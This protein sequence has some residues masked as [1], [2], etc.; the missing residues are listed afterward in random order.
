[1][2]RAKGAV[3]NGIEELKQRHR[4][5]W[6]MGDYP[7]IAEIFRDE[8][9]ATVEAA[10]ISAGDEVLDVA[11]GNGNIAI[12]A[13]RRGARVVATDLSPH[14]VELGRDRTAAEG[15]E[16]EWGEADVEELP[17]ENDRFDIVTSSFGAMFAPRPERAAAEMFRVAKPGGRV[18]M[19]NWVPEGPM[20]LISNLMGKYLPGGPEGLP[21]PKEWGE[22]NTAR[23]RFG[24]NAEE[25]RFVRGAVHWD[26]EDSEQQMSFLTESAPPLAAAKAVLPPERY[27]ELLRELEEGYKQMSIDPNRVTYDADYLIVI[28]TKR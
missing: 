16:V 15:V 18:V 13:A 10:G 17:F 25:V 6:G 12:E 8:A 28:G 22:Q 20:D 21:D 5:L 19:T 26:F 24:P 7:R 9:V 23:Q 4:V 1:M 2:I 3:L 11:A 14:M 27:E